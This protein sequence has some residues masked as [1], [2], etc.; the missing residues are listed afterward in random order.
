MAAKKDT[1]RNIS[2]RMP[3]DIV[4]M[5]A[6]ESGLD[7]VPLSTWITHVAGAEAARRQGKP[8]PPLRRSSEPPEVSEAIQSLQAVAGF[9]GLTLET[10][11]SALQHVIQ[12]KTGGT[13]PP[14]SESG[15]RP[16]IRPG[17][18]SL[19]R[20]LTPAALNRAVRQGAK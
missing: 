9:E 2:I 6:V 16:T 14:K 12:S 11:V 1:H 8:V 13:L 5:I 15:M 19:T 3:H 17:E 4:E 7:G 10:L 20:N 18:Y